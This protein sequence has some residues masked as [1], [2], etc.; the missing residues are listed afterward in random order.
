[1]AGGIRPGTVTI[2]VLIGSH[3]KPSYDLSCA[4]VPSS[5]ADRWPLILRFSPDTGHP[6]PVETR[7][8][9]VPVVL[10]EEFGRGSS[11]PTRLGDILRVESEI[12]E[13]TRSRS[14]P[15]QVGTQ[16]SA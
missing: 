14:K 12:V 13:I 2:V 1:M 16:C 15:N 7:V 4:L 6:Q 11:G 5:Q 10:E 3:Y 9:L 8:R